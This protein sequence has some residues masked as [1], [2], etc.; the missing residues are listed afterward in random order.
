M[1][2]FVSKL[3]WCNSVRIAPLIFAVLCGAVFFSASAQTFLNPAQAFRFSAKLVNAATAPVIEARFTT[4]PGY[5]LYREKFAFTASNGVVLGV[6]DIPRGVVKF[7]PNFQKEVETHAGELVV[8]IPVVQGQG[9]FTLTA[10]LQGCAEAG[11]CYP[12]EQ[13]VAQLAFNTA[14]KKSLESSASGGAL[15][16]SSVSLLT[17]NKSDN[18]DSGNKD[19]GRIQRALSSGS[20]PTVLGIFF[21]LGLLLSFTP[22]VLP[23]LPIL[24]ALIAGQTQSGGEGVHH[25]YALSRARGFSLAL[26]YS[27]GM[28]LV[29]TALG[30][31][32]GL[33]GEGL[34]ATL[35]QPLWLGAFAVVMLLLALAM[36]GVYELQLPSSWQA[37]LSQWSTRH[38]NGQLLGVFVM[39]AISAF[40]IG[41][42]VAAPLAGALLYISQT[43]DVLLGGTALFSLALGMSVPLLLIG[44]SAGSVL[45]RVGPWMTGI[46]HALGMGLLAVALWTLNPLL[47]TWLEMLTWALWLA[48]AAIGLG[49]FQS[50]ALHPGRWFL[51]AI[52]AVFLVL[53]VLQLVGVASGGRDLLRPLEKLA[54]LESPIAGAVAG[55]ATA[56][57][58]QAAA[59]VWQSVASLEQLNAALQNMQGKP[60]LLYFWAEWC[61]SCHEMERFT[62][63]DPQVAQRLQNLVLLKVDVT[64]NSAADKALLKRFSLFGPPGLIFFNPQGQILGEPWVGFQS[65]ERFLI[66]LEKIL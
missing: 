58:S 11:L 22:C 66:V 57:N 15:V 12:P 42:C 60:V 26:A 4:A 29:Y 41:P 52:G 13:R 6:P 24:S 27:L 49:L 3:R 28:A 61:V 47:P 43:R 34:A 32:A 36:F 25:R 48:M 9:A 8:R 53:A 10:Y 50:Q 64:E 33:A 23:M 18:P 59:P 40:I 45:P 19:S 2:G 54:R 62:F 17:D 37:R 51:K 16:S 46:K 31:A 55:A 63:S 30:I 65:A 56:A 38:S 39:G 20:L 35:Q 14:E 21:V 5:Y 44:L 7:D 1:S